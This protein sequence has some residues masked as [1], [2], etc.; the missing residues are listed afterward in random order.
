R[1]GNALPH[2]G[3]LF[4][5]M[6]LLVVVA[7]GI[8]AQ[9]DLVVTHPGTGK[10]IRPVN[11]ISGSWQVAG[12]Q[13]TEKVRNR[14]GGCRGGAGQ[15]ICSRQEHGRSICALARVAQAR[16]CGNGV[17]AHDPSRGP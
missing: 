1:V 6:A 4:A 15:H 10:E 8:A 7:S 13:P 2:P 14:Q 3:T 12:D 11:S 9:F 5:L 16:S 17:V